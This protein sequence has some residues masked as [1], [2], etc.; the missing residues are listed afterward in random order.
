[1]FDD[2][3]CFTRLAS[4]ATSARAFFQ[5]RAEQSKALGAWFANLLAMGRKASY[6]LDRLSE[7]KPKALES[8]CN[9]PRVVGLVAKS[10]GAWNAV[11]CSNKSQSGNYVSKVPS[12][13]FHQF[14]ICLSKWP[15]SRCLVR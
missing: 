9:G 10:P 15:Q 3:K 11:N 1:M 14:T 8:V 12:N 6:S 5:K 7:S 2:G 4:P 13:N